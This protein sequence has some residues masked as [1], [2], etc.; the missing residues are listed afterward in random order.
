MPCC[1]L[2]ARLG[3][4]DS[5]LLSQGEEPRCTRPGHSY[6]SVR[7][8]WSVVSPKLRVLL[9]RPLSPPAPTSA[10]CWPSSVHPA[11]P[12]ASSSPAKPG[13]LVPIVDRAINP[14]R[15]IVINDPS[16]TTVPLTFTSGPMIHHR[17]W[18]NA[19]LRMI[20]SGRPQGRVG[21]DRLAESAAACRARRRGEGYRP[22][23]RPSAPLEETVSALDEGSNCLV[24]ER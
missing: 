9:V 14:F 19:L 1:C 17:I 16:N 20:T 12:N 8:P 3:H 10:G 5:I 7:Q 2:R 13:L 6:A 22:L 21:R 18:R 4:A 15:T 24:S 11:A 23:T